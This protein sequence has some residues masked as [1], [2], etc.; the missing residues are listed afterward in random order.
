MIESGPVEVLVEGCFKEIN[1]SKCGKKKKDMFMYLTESL[2][3][4]AEIITTL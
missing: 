2:C 4:I 3:C 1:F